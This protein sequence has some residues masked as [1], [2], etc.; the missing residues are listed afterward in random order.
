[1]K[2]WYRAGSACLALD[3]VAE[4]LDACRNG[5]ACDPSSA[6]LQALQSRTEKRRDDLAAIEHARQ[7]RE[8]R[9]RDEQETLRHALASRNI[10]TRSTTESPPDMEDAVIA[11]ENPLDAASSLSLPVMFLYPL[12]AQSDLV[13]ACREDESLGQHLQYILPT[14]WDT[15]Q[16]YVARDVECYM[17]T[18]QGGLIKAGKNLSLLRLLASGKV[19]VTDRLVKVNVVPKVKA[20]GW[21]EV[22]KQRRGKT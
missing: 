7:Q 12:H 1:M 8:Q 15:G 5:L 13:K 6:A 3:K 4:A 16:E 20:A 11:L 22:F 19:A 21:L 2:A 14:P 10:L 17:E 9:S 18:I